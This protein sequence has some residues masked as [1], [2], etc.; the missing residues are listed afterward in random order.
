MRKH[1]SALFSSP[2]QN[3]DLA[4]GQEEHDAL[5]AAIAGSNKPAFVS[6]PGVS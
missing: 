4:T 2:F 5:A 3:G 1:L 6:D